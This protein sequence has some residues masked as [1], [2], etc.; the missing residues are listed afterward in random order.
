MARICFHI[1]EQ[2][3]SLHKG[4]SEW[5]VAE[6]CLTARM[7]CKEC[8]LSAQSGHL[9]STEECSNDRGVQLLLPQAV[10]PS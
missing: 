6:I 8:K 3:R 1:G 9:N 7:A 4:K 10:N 2:P 5:C